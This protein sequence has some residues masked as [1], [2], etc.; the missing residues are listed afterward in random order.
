[1]PYKFAFD[2]SRIPR[3]FFKEIA[4][5]G[6]QASVH[7]KVGKTAQ[8]IIKKFK[9]DEA[10][11]L[12]L[13]DAVIVIQDLIDMQARNIK[14][15]EKFVQTKKRA[16]FLPH[17]SRKYMD[18]RCNATF[19]PN[20]PSYVC[21]H[22]STDCLINKATTLAKKKGYDVYILPGGSCVPK[23]LSSKRYEGIVGVACGEEIRLGG[24]ITQHMDVA[25]QA[26]PL[27][28]NGCANTIFNI[29]TLIKTL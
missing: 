18:N 9:I 4:I 20:I 16:L 23:I 25:S 28:K 3:F 19:D 13:S 5:V 2:L 27:I 1:M 14:E 22:C 17:C 29:E 24:E 21:A 7:K 6:Y 10:T 26:V 8:E 11:G 15:R 12:N